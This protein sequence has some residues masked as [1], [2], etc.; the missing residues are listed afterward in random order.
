MAGLMTHE[1]N[2]GCERLARRAAKGVPGGFVTSLATGCPRSPRTRDEIRAI[3]DVLDATA[4][5]F[6]EQRAAVAAVA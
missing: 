5:R 2:P 1:P 3:P 4:R 6:E